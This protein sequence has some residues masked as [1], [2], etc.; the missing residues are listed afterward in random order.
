MAGALSAE[1]FE[2]LLIEIRDGAS[3]ALTDFAFEQVKGGQANSASIEDLR[4]VWH[5]A[6]IALGLL[7]P[8]YVPKYE[9][10]YDAHE[11]VRRYPLEEDDER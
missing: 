8:K 9:A 10:L 1:Q 11:L 2:A 4:T 7:S 6:E 3:S 5:T